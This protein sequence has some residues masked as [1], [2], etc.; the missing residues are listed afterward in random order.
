MELEDCNEDV[1]LRNQ[2]WASRQSWEALTSEWLDTRLDQVAPEV[3]E[4]QVQKYNKAVYK[5]ERGLVP[6]KV[7]WGAVTEACEPNNSI[8]WLPYHIKKII[9]R[10][11]FCFLVCLIRLGAEWQFKSRS[12]PTQQ[13]SSGV[14]KQG[15][16]KGAKGSFGG[17]NHGMEGEGFFSTL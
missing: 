14:L 8:V 1:N 3:L 2:L 15:R 9:T 4:E 7:R 13:G 10:S 17:A 6:N 11:R 12:C 16:A 5:M